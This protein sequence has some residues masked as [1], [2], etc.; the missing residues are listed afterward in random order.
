VV[1]RWVPAGL[2][3]WRYILLGKQDGQDDTSVGSEIREVIAGIYGAL[4]M[5]ERSGV[6]T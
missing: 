1:A 5:C 3:E 6:V 4:R 2:G